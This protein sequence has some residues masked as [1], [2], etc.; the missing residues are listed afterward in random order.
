MNKLANGYTYRHCCNSKNYR[1]HLVCWIMHDLLN[2]LDFF[3][4]IRF[5]DNVK[6]WGGLRKLWHLICIV[7]VLV[8]TIPKWKHQKIRN[9]VLIIQ[10]NIFNTLQNHAISC[11]HVNVRFIATYC[12]PL[13]IPA[14]LKQQMLTFMW[15]HKILSY[16][17]EFL[18]YRQPIV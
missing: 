5:T 6:A 14:S 7:P 13:L 12:I 1:K 15:Y 9:I 11:M 2:L 10:P 17:F 16:I 3:S 18:L 8:S 4:V